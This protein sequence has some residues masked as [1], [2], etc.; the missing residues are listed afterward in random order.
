M[1]KAPKTTAGT[2][3]SRAKAARPEVT[4]LGEHLAALLN[5]A[6]NQRQLGVSEAAQTDHISAPTPP[7]ERTGV[8][9]P[10]DSLKDLLERGDPNIREKKPWIPHR[11]PRPDKSEGGQKFRVA[12]EFE[13]DGDQPG[14]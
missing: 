7:P 2:R 6:L 3:T 8:A 1:A 10:V 9:A 4:P 5:P 14:A 11:P 12:S 13:P